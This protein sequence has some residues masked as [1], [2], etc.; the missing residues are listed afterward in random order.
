M[1]VSTLDGS[2]DPSSFLVQ[3]LDRMYPLWAA[4][5]FPPGFR[6]LRK[7]AI[8]VE[9]L[10]P[11]IGDLQRPAPEDVEVLFLLPNVEYLYLG[12]TTIGGDDLQTRSYGEVP[13]RG[14]NVQHLYFNWSECTAPEYMRLIGYA[15][16]LKSC[17]FSAC[18]CVMM[19][20]WLAPGEDVPDDP[21]AWDGER[22]FAEVVECL[23]E[24]HGSTL[25]TLTFSGGDLPGDIAI[26]AGQFSARYTPSA[27]T[28][29]EKLR[30]VTIDIRD[31]YP[32]SE[33]AG[34]EERQIDSGDE[35]FI[36]KI[37]RSMSEHLPA[38]IEVLQIVDN[39][40]RATTILEH[41]KVDLM[42]SHFIATQHCP[43]LKV[44]DLRGLCNNDERSRDAFKHVMSLGKQVDDLTIFTSVND[45][46]EQRRLLA[47]M[48]EAV[49]RRDLMTAPRVVRATGPPD[50]S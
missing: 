15:K 10:L 1:H 36:V 8:G 6:S 45:L 34:Y 3:P 11:S 12:L 49:T 28:R 29:F 17:T 50:D 13:A 27:L 9:N 2:H 40:E 46:P 18:E 35:D 33:N 23:A 39:D 38:S 21:E 32:T 47:G 20:D 25:E 42:L 31:F 16:A 44:L 26:N 4:T 48:P 24:Q 43:K 30:H 5:S 14:S 37:A 22:G 41:D 19:T 7:V